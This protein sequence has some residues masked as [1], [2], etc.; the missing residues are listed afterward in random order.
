M[1]EGYRDHGVPAYLGLG[2]YRAQAYI[3][4]LKALIP[5]E[6][7]KAPEPVKKPEPVVLTLDSLALFE[8]GQFELKNNA[9]KALI[10]VLKAIE[11][12]PDTRILVEAIPIMLAILFL[13]SSCQKNGPNPSKTG[14]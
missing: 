8:T 11:S 13:I 12:H 14:W 7:P 3:P 6:V 4:K 5:A 1:L 10:G 2:L 9:N